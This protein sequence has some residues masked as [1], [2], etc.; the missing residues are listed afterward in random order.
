MPKLIVRE[1]K[2]GEVILAKRVKDIGNSYLRFLRKK[3]TPLIKFEW[4]S[5][6]NIK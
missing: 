2:R 4:R 5:N 6:S 1:R 3:K